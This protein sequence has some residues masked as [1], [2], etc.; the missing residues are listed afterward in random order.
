MQKA[1]RFHMRDDLFAFDENR[2]DLSHQ[3][4]SAAGQ[5]VIRLANTEFVKENVEQPRVVILPG[6]YNCMIAQIVKERYN[7]AESDNFRPGSEDGHNL[8]RRNSPSSTTACP[9]MRL[10]LSSRLRVSSS[11]I[12]ESPELYSLVSDRTPGSS[13]TSSGNMGLI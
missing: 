3:C 13:F 7:S 1:V 5:K 9:I 6:M 4:V 10:N 8:H 2:C 12:R 11:V